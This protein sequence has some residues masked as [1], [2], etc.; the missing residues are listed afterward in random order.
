[1]GGQARFINLDNSSNTPDGNCI[2]I[3]YHSCL[4]WI[5]IRTQNRGLTMPQPSQ[6]VLLRINGLHGF[7]I[8][9]NFRNPLKINTHRL[10]V[11]SLSLD[12][13][14]FPHNVARIR[15]CPKASFLEYDDAQYSRIFRNMTIQRAIKN[16]VTC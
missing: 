4:L 15:M 7:S 12:M 6:P 16:P 10:C 3:P 2:C 1:M 13:G 5:P 8:A 11:K 14:E 9:P